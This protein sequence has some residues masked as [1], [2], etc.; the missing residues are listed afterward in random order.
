MHGTSLCAK[1]SN[2]DKQSEQQREKTRQQSGLRKLYWT[3]QWKATRRAVL[4]RDPICG[5]EENGVRCW[6]IST[7]CHHVI[8]AEIWVVRGGDFFDESNLAGLCKRHH[9]RHTAREV[10]FAQSKRTD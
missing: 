7:D 4:A 8:D 2:A 3:P 1:H 10:G 5:H 9:S 6:G